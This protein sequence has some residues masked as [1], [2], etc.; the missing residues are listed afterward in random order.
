MNG[1]LRLVTIDSLA[2]LVMAGGG[3]IGAWWLRRSSR[4]SIRN[5]YLPALLLSAGTLIALAVRDWT[6]A[7]VLAPLTASVLAASV[8]GR[9]WRLADLGAGEELRSHELERRWIWQPAPHRKD[10]ERVRLVGQGELVRDRPWPAGLAYVPLYDQGER[11]PRVPIGAGQHVMLLGATGSGKTTTARRIIAARTLTQHAAVLVLDQKGDPDDVEQM[12]RLAAAADVPFILFDS[13]DPDTDRWAPLWGSPDSVAARAV[14]PIRQSEPYYYDTLRR[15]LDLVCKILHA[16]DRWPPSVPF[17]IDACH[18]ARYET[19]TGLAEALDPE[20]HSSLTRRAA[21]HAGYVSSAQG[22]KDLLGGVNRL[23]VALAL[24]GRRMVTPRMTP[25]G[26]A[27]AVSLPEA[28]RAGAVIVWRTH[29]DAMPD[30]AAALS[31]LALA[32]IHEA[33]G[34]AG[35]PWTLVLDEFGA[36]I[37]TAAQRALAALQ[38]GRSHNG[39]VIVVT[40]SAADVEALTGQTGLL[41]SLT[42]NFAAII[43]HRQTA[44][45]SRDW[46]AKLMGTRA[47][48]QHTNQT[49]SHGAQHSGQ[50][51][52]RR[53]REFRV[54]SDTF[55]ALRRGEAI[56]YIPTTGEPTCHT[57]TPVDLPLIPAR[58][59]DR[60]EKRVMSEIALHP[61]DH[62]SIA[63]HASEPTPASPPDDGPEEL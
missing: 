51:S 39:Q 5:L 57:V 22:Q 3:L 41:A 1:I 36:V 47:L 23:E 60:S 34:I 4:L 53:V 48:W 16:A 6:V 38:R 21:E 35:V 26:T 10:G 63:S 9:R 19:L 14:E 56:I 12:R 11:A 33:A 43:A 30:E 28:M 49:T 59:T 32:D 18:P 37:Q 8:T 24:A 31:V 54:G 50:G 27:V 61:E 62:L 25:D 46:L 7:A 17:L 29:A 20:A 13:Q 58:A 2:T 44:P 42:D 15:H 55:G 52:A 45:E 40:Q